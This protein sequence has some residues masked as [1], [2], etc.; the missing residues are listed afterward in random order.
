M[1]YMFLAGTPKNQ[2]T[3]EKLDQLLA[4]ANADNRVKIIKKTEN[5]IELYIEAE[6]IE[7][8]VYSFG[9]ICN[10][11]NE[12]PSARK[13]RLEK[14][15]LPDI[16][17]ITNFMKYS[18]R[19]DQ[20]IR[21][22]PRYTL[23]CLREAISICKPSVEKAQLINTLTFKLY[24]NESIADRIVRDHASIEGAKRHAQLLVNA[25][26]ANSINNRIGYYGKI[27]FEDG[28]EL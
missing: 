12:L 7:S 15:L 3:T 24:G 11:L 21:S 19:G 4:L 2:I 18:D 10:H 6:E 20:E 28:S 17:N 13:A 16:I 14:E 5:P 27:I 22:L 8:G 1:S 26:C 9:R 25:G 23:A